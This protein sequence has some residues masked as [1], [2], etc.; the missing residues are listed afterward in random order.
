MPTHT[1][2]QELT[3]SERESFRAAL[4]RAREAFGR[5]EGVLGVGFG[6]KRTNGLF[7]DV[8][9]ITVTVSRKTPPAAL[10][11]AD[12]IPATFEDYPTDVMAV[13]R[14]SATIGCDNDTDYTGLPGG[15]QGGIQIVPEIVNAGVAYAKG[16][17]GC[18][19]R[20]RGD[21][22]RENVYLLTCKHVLFSDGAREGHPVYHPFAQAPKGQPPAGP[23]TVLGPIQKLAYRDNV[24]YSAAGA[25]TPQ[26]FYLDC[27]TARI[28]IDCKCFNSTCTKDHLKYSPAI[29]DLGLGSSNLVAGVRDAIDDPGIIGKQVFK[30]GRATGRT[31]GLVRQLSAVEPLEPDP[32]DPAA[33]TSARSVMRIDFDKASTPTHLNCLGNERF[34]EGGDSGSV[35]VDENRNVVGLVAISAAAAHANDPPPKAYPTYACHIFPVLDLL[36]ICIATD[37]SS[38]SHGCCTATDG[39][40]LTSAPPPQTAAP[41]GKMAFLNAGVAAAPSVAQA[42]ITDEQRA[43]MLALRDALV[44]SPSGR[45][46]H[47]TFVRVRREL[48]YLVRNSRPVKVVWHRNHGPAYLAHIL[49]HLKGDSPAVPHEVRGISRSDFLT[50]MGAVLSAQG[51]IPMRDA[52]ARYRV[53]LLPVLVSANDIADCLRALPDLDPS[54]GDFVGRAP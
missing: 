28:D 36:K 49:N 51:S 42:E 24:P 9:A 22:D 50:R 3:Q 43:R 23:S 30:V 10:S 6:Q 48:G 19:V 45:E 41:T 8:V 38:T 32:D 27:A 16:T 20:R 17:L 47:D 46:L 29:V 40:G 34:A 1:T 5:I 18:I 4:W 54:V 52:I 2:T 15:I 44:A 12:T 11:A 7:L 26:T 13:G 37:G 21:K 39:S 53:E 25:S 31:A 35:V 33:P 14:G